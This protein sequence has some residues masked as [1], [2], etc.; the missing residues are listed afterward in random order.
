MKRESLQRF[1]FANG[2]ERA[3]EGHKLFE[4]FDTLGTID[5]PKTLEAVTHLENLLEQSQ[6]GSR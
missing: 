1:R 4:N 5:W 2:V 3:D 6:V